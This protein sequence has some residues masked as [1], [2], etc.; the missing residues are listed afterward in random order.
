M[1]RAQH[2]YANF[3]NNNVIYRKNDIEHSVKIINVWWEFQRSNFDV[4]HSRTPTSQT[5][6]SLY[7][8]SISNFDDFNFDL[9]KLNEK[10][11]TRLVF[12]ICTFYKKS[13]YQFAIFNL[14]IIKNLWTT[15]PRGNPEKSHIFQVIRCWLI[16]ITMYPR[17]K[18]TFWLY[19]HIIKTKQNVKRFK[20]ESI[21]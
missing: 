12:L 6:I 20:Q 9:R 13:L 18:K 16:F 4:L 1:T 15:R 2:K 11:T 19:Y 14:R 10:I 5:I 21:T 7:H 3:E 17:I 8:W